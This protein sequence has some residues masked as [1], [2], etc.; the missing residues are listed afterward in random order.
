[1]WIPRTHIVFHVINLVTLVVSLG[2]RTSWR[3]CNPQSLM[4]LELRHGSLVRRGWW[5]WTT[6]PQTHGVY[7]G[8]TWK[9]GQMMGH[10]GNRVKGQIF[11]RSSTWFAK[12]D[13]NRKTTHGRRSIVWKIIL[14]SKLIDCIN[15]QLIVLVDNCLYL[16]DGI[17]LGGLNGLS[18]MISLIWLIMIDLIDLVDLND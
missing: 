14:M 10:D 9:G 18:W 7:Y 11:A 4:D 2:T 12:M 6:N 8:Y 13:N 15:W 17:W 5:L 16:I 3:P 1:M